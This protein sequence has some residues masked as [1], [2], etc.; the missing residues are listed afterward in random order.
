[1][2]V[3]LYDANGAQTGTAEAEDEP[4]REGVVEHGGKTY[5][6]NQRN[7]QWREAA[8]TVK[9]KGSATAAAPAEGPKVSTSQ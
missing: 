1:M 4:G 8:A 7:A 6:W 3:K 2:E 5:V 9:L